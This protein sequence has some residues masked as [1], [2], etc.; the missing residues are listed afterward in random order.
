MKSLPD[1]YSYSTEPQRPSLQPPV[2]TGAPESMLPVI[3][4]GAMASLIV[5]KWWVVAISAILAAAAAAAYLVKQPDI[6]ESHAVVYVGQ[7]SD[8][9]LQIQ[10]VSPG[11]FREMEELMTVEQSLA[12]SS[13]LLRV[14]EANGLREDASFA[15][16][17]ETGRPYSDNLLVQILGSRV[18]ASLR[19]GTRLIDVFVEDTDPQRAQRI[20]RSVVEEFT[21]MSYE[22]SLQATRRAKESLLDE[23]TRL[24]ERLEQSEQKLQS[25]RQQ[26]P[27]LPLGNNES[28]VLAKLKK[29]ND[30]L[31]GSKSERLR[32]ETDVEQ[33]DR[34]DVRTPE[35]ILRLGTVAE[36]DE[37]VELQKSINQK[38]AE[39]AKIQQRYAFK[40]PTYISID[41]ELSELR[42]ALRQNALAAGETIRKRYEAAKENEQKLFTAVES[43]NEQL[44]GLD[45]S[46]MGLR[47]LQRDVDS[48]R[49]LFDAVQHR[50]KETSVSEGILESHLRLAEEPMVADFPMKPRK[51][52]VLAM[53]FVLGCGIGAGLILLL[54]FL[55]S[56]VR[57]AGQV[58]RALG[59]PALATIP[60]TDSG[61]LEKGIA[62]RR[63]PNSRTAEAFRMLRTSLSFTGLQ[64][65]ARSV[66]FTSAMPDEGKSFSAL[67]YAAALA[68]Q[69]YRTLLI[70]ADL[71]RPSLCKA[72]LHEVES[73]GLSDHLSGTIDPGDA[74]YSTEFE[75]LFFLPSGKA[76]PNPAEL[77]GD[78]RFPQLLAE[79]YRWFDRII[80]DSSPV[81]VVSDAISVANCVQSVCLVVRAGKTPR[82]EA[83]KACRYLQR[84]GAPLAGFV[85]NGC[86]DSPRFQGYYTETM[87]QAVPQQPALAA[88]GN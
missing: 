52:L 23:S 4:L 51:K 11:D 75:N 38:E 47:S 26:N 62:I 49:E 28:I 87:P 58:E 36:K 55:D 39:F 20:A 57:T 56:S 53:A 67:N 30:D 14:V 82:K 68:S 73:V 72:L 69:G 2:D 64:G 24:R 71:R 44:L 80:I 86:E 79:A 1:S 74:C 48:D 37:I 70:D 7:E 29:L 63:D 40:H 43:Q 81:G 61:G 8:R 59:V 16:M 25:Y 60:E 17:D 46:L 66:L 54:D 9:V 41:T 32:L 77:L 78:E 84:S 31:S 6:Y 65:P 13:V 19:R 15:P 33:L 22:Q 88:Y 42:E 3:D 50:L 83:L 76:S 35:A 27:D 18:Q 5:R 45:D 10:A 85:L 12:S 34:I 21:S